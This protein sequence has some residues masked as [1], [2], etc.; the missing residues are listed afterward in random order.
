[1]ADDKKSTAESQTKDRFARH[2]EEA[3]RIVST[4]PGWKQCVLGG[5]GSAPALRKD[6]PM[7]QPDA[8]R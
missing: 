3:S 2:L 1:M 5:R 4:W 7:K 8:A 6:Q